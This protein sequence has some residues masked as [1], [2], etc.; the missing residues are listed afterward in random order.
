MKKEH[1]QVNEI[2]GAFIGMTVM[3]SLKLPSF[4]F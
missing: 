4:Y 3:L 1:Q 2:V